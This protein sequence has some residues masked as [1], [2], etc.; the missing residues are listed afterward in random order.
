[1]TTNDTTPKT[2]TFT[3]KAPKP[4]RGDIKATATIRDGYFSVTGE[5]STEGERKHGDAQAC[6]CIHDEISQVFPNLRPLIALHL[7]DALSGEPMH[8][9]A[10]GFYWLAGAVGGLGQEYHGG[11][12]SS[13]KSASDCLQIFADYWRISLAEA[14]E[15]AD[16]ATAE[17][18]N[19]AA[20]LR[21]EYQEARPRW[22]AEAAEGR[23]F[24][25]N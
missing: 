1:M 24:F 4:W 20:I 14:Q 6:G 23:A 25:R 12:G 11:N 7:S 15:I 8:A 3:R 17:G 21:H 22:A 5:I 19:A 9:E 13:G 10:N 16:K 18:A 2:A